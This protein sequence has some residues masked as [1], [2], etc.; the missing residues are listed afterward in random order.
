LHNIAHLIR[1]TNAI[2]TAIRDNCFTNDFAPWKT[3]SIAHH[4]W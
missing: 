1:F 2:S 4:T 3:S